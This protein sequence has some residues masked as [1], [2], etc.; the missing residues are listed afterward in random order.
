MSSQKIIGLVVIGLIILGIF[1]YTATIFTPRAEAPEVSQV[2]P[3]ETVK[4]EQ[5]GLSFAYPTGD[6]G[7]TLIEPP[8]ATSSALLAS[9]MLFPTVPYRGLKEKT[10]PGEVPAGIHIF[11]FSTPKTAKTETE[12]TT[13]ATED[14]MTRLLKWANDNNSI[15]SVTKAKTS[16]AT[17]T[18][19]GLK[20]LQYQADGLYQQDIYLTSYKNRVYMLVGQYTDMN[21][22]TYTAFQELLK[23]VAFE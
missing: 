23:T 15:T 10:E 21:D 7:F 19:D 13:T 6:T 17:V 18:L 1:Y 12:A 4:R 14:R 8:A 11:V 16:P 20:T 5:I 9:F 22:Y 2:A 3:T